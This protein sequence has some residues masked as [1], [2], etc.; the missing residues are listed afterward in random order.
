MLPGV[1]LDG[2]NA[3]VGFIR[4]C[5]ND[6]RAKLIAYSIG[7]V[8]LVAAIVLTCIFLSLSTGIFL[9][10]SLLYTCF[11][12][13]DVYLREKPPQSLTNPTY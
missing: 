8:I 5:A 1:P 10:L 13:Y 4:L 3:L 6:G 2:S 9:I 11:A 12:L 7:C